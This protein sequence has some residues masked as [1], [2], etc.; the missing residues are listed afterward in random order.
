[1]RPLFFHMRDKQLSMLFLQCLL[2]DNG[3]PRVFCMSNL[4][5]LDVLGFLFC[6]SNL[7]LL[8]FL[9]CCLHGQSHNAAMLN[10]AVFPISTL[11]VDPGWVVL[12]PQN[13]GFPTA[14]LHVHSQNAGF[15]R[16]FLHVHLGTYELIMTETTYTNNL[17]Q[18]RP[19]PIHTHR[20]TDTHTHTETDT[21]T[22]T[23]THT[24]TP[25]PT[26]ACTLHWSRFVY[27][28]F[29][30]AHTHASTHRIAC[31]TVLCVV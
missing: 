15:P 23:H 29:F 27:G 1:M 19:P 5:T 22:H 7:K 31:V 11:L 17:C 25:T 9:G 2:S 24:H 4:K 26:R 28:F 14:F 13:A 30:P 21:H 12:H 16:V 18:T 6:M 20:H 3:F 8:N 10:F